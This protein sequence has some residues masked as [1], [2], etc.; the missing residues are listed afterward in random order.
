MRVKLAE[1]E[2]KMFINVTYHAIIGLPYS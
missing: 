1:E 2:K